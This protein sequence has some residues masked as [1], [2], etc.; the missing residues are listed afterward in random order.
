MAN[1]SVATESAWVPTDTFGHRL[2]LIRRE[3]H[4]NVKEAAARC[5]VHYATWSTWENGTKPGDLAGVVQAI[6]RELKVDRD[7]LMWGG[8][9]A[10]SPPPGDGTVSSAGS[11]PGFGLDTVVPFLSRTPLATPVPALANAA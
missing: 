8:P 7:W 1:M 6:S 3:L 2:V 9:L 5:G 4:L 11:R 10:Q